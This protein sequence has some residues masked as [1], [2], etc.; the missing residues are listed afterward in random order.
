MCFYSVVFPWNSA[1]TGYFQ[2]KFNLSEST[3]SRIAGTIYYV[4]F[5]LGPI[6]GQLIDLFGY[7][8]WVLLV[9]QV[10]ILPALWMFSLSSIYPL[11]PMLLLGIS[12]SVVPPIL[13]GSV[14]LMV[15]MHI[16]GTA[17][18][19]LSFLQMLGVAL[20][21]IAVGYLREYSGYTSMLLFFAG[22]A[23]L[24]TCC[25][26]FLNVA[27]GSQLNSKSPAFPH[28]AEEVRDEMDNDQQVTAPASSHVA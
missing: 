20:T 9:G 25:G 14:D 3:A 19:V 15:P 4:A 27:V 18:G 13:W 2:S 17:M 26:I 28:G 22:L 10:V 24:G 16:L 7:R 12:Y 21:Q 11:I 6:G 1:S 8:G 5:I 23:T